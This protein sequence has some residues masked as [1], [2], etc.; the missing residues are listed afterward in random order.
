MAVETVH[1]EQSAAPA[2]SDASGACTA[3]LVVADGRA[4]GVRPIRVSVRGRL[5]A[6]V[7][8]T[9]AVTSRTSPSTPA[10]QWGWRGSRCSTGCHSRDSSSASQ[11]TCR[12]CSSLEAYRNHGIGEALVSAVITEAR[13]RGVGYL[14]VHPSVRAYPLYERLGFAETNQ[15]LHMDLDGDAKTRARRSDATASGARSGLVA[16][17][18]LL[19]EPVVRVGLIVEGRDFDVPG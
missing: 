8:H 1:G 13:T 10:S 19:L 18:E 4:R 9:H 5:H 14:I 3:A 7:E 16:A 12:A 2:S 6:V 17:P 11:A 15:M